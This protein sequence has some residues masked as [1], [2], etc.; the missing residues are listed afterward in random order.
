MERHSEH[1]GGA[2][3]LGGSELD[4]GAVGGCWVLGAGDPEFDSARGGRWAAPAGVRNDSFAISRK[5][6][7]TQDEKKRTK[8]NFLIFFPSFPLK[9][10]NI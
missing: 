1:D 7:P 10:A 2:L 4:D 3:F 5:L 9:I 8:I 6:N